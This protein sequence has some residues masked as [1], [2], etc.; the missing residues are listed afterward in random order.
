MFHQFSLA[1]YL[2]VENPNALKHIINNNIEQT[3]VSFTVL[4][5]E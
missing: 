4:P 3:N 5:L 1:F 2:Q